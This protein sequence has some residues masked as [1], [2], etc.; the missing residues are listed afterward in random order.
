MSG[1]VIGAAVT[2]RFFMP[3]PVLA[4]YISTYYLTEVNIAPG[5]WI[6]ACAISNAS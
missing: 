1:K 3:S 2:V 5:Q 6:E 4:P